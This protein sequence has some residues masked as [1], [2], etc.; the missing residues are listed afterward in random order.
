ML[1]SQGLGRRGFVGI[2]LGEK[3]LSIYLVRL[4]WDRYKQWEV[5]WPE[6]NLPFQNEFEQ[7]M[8]FLGG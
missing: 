6:G 2:S 8:C 7:L 4:W 5:R 1:E 3:N